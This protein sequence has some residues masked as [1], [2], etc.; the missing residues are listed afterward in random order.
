[1][2][3]E[4][5]SRYLTAL[6]ELNLLTSTS[7]YQ[8]AGQDLAAPVNQITDDIHTFLINSDTKGIE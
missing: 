7:Y 8:A 4:V 5:A 2:M 3:D 6:D 1:M